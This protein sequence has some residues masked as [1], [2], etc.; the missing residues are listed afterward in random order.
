MA[1]LRNLPVGQSVGW[2]K[3]SVPTIA[4][5]HAERWWARRKCAFAHPIAYFGAALRSEITTSLLI[6]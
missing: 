3:R 2:A 6:A 5:A 4:T 1:R